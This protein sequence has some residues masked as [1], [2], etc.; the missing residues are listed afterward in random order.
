MTHLAE[1]I[2]LRTVLDATQ[3]PTTPFDKKNPFYDSLS[4]S[5]PRRTRGESGH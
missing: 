3:T 1:G 4:G 2:L 5:C